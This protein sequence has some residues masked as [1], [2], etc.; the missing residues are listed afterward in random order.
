MQLIR[1]KVK[2][3]KMDHIFITHLHG[4]HYFGL[5]GLITSFHLMK[6]EKPLTIFCPRDLKPILDIQLSASNTVLNFTLNYHYLTEGQSELLFEDAHLQIKSFPLKHSLPVWG[7]RFQEKKQRKRL[8]RSFAEEYHPSKTEIEHILSGG[9]YILPNGDILPHSEITHDSPIPL[10]YVFCG[11]TCPLESTSDYA[12]DATLLYHEGT[13]D[14]S[15]EDLAGIT[16]HSTARQAAKVAK[17][18]NVRRLL[19]GHYS[20]R[21]KSDLS[22]IEKEAKEVFEPT[23]LSR[24]GDEIKLSDI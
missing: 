1:H 16:L 12:K 17:A 18:A 8:S 11:D 13:F 10:S 3:K 7:F 21:F 15:L 2:L 20:A 14:D 6:R 23:V 4:D 19:L 5:I 22:I 9:N 24:E